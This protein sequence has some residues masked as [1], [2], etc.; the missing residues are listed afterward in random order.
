MTEEII[1]RDEVTIAEVLVLP[2]KCTKQSVLIAALRL[3][4]RSSQQKD[5]RFTV[6]NVFRNTG[7]P[8]KT[9]HREKTADT[10]CFLCKCV[11]IDTYLS[12]FG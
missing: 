2:E 7:H 8:E 9:A 4:S 12:F 10:K 3:K 5:G 6:E 11:Y 1:L